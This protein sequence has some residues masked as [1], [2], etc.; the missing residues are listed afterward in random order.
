MHCLCACRLENS[1]IV[2]QKLLTCTPCSLTSTL[3]KK[4]DPLPHRRWIGGDMEGRGGIDAMGV[5]DA[6]LDAMSA[7]ELIVAVAKTEQVCH[8]WMHAQHSCRR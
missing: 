3:N 7:L 5:K 8:T 6:G 2:A 4:T 1:A